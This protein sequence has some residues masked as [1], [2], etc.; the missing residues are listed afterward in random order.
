MYDL[1]TKGSFQNMQNCNLK[2]NL[3]LI[4]EKKKINHYTI[5]YEY[6]FFKLS[7]N[8]FAPSSRSV[9]YP[10]IITCFDIASHCPC[11]L[12]IILQTDRC[13]QIS[14]RKGMDRNLVFPYN[15]ITIY[16]VRWI[17]SELII[18]Q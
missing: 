11:G 2:T 18:K 6:L 12:V 7:S 9:S 15:L 16:V 8:Q 4:G 14:S 13:I 1:T 10:L 3:D 17:F 5:I